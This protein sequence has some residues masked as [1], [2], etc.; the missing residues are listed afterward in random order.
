MNIKKFNRWFDIKLT[1]NKN[2]EVEWDT[3]RSWF[4]LN[5]GINT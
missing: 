3:D 2:I 5:A 4:W 1:E